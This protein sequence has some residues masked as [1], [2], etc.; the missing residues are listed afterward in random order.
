MGGFGLT[1]LVW[2]PAALTVNRDE[3]AKNSCLARLYTRIGVAADIA[4]ETKVELR[5]HN[6]AGSL[7]TTVL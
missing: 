1:G 4:Q 3:A 2:N 5:L 7:S 6:Q